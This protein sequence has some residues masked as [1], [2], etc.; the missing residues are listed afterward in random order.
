[1]ELN[2]HMLFYPVG[3]HFC[4]ET[5]PISDSLFIADHTKSLFGT[6]YLC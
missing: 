2:A 4:V 1:M 3:T 6:Y 5:R